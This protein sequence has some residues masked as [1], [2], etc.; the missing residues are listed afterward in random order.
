M[1]KKKLRYEI[2]V[3]DYQIRGNCRCCKFF[4]RV[5]EHNYRNIFNI[6][7][8]CRLG[9]LNGEYNLFVSTSFSRECPAFVRDEYN[10][11]TWKREYNLRK[12]HSEFEYA[13]IDGRTRLHKL[14]R[15]HAFENEELKKFFSDDIGNRWVSLY[16][17]RKLRE[18]F[19]ELFLRMYKD[20]F[21]WLYHRKMLKES[22]Y[23]SFLN[24]L[25]TLFDKFVSVDG[26]G[27]V[28]D[29]YQ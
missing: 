4:H 13:L 16:I 25:R 6:R 12:K 14:I 3:G 29:I 27:E 24:K 8:F 28:V 11:E 17:N 26:L 23:H 20:D 5:F 9:R 19:Y 1:G 18:D 22:D 2:D 21:D 15:K 10:T 7:G